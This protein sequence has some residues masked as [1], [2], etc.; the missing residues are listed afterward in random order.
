[1]TE[2]IYSLT[3]R[4]ERMNRIF[5]DSSK[6]RNCALLKSLN[7]DDNDRKKVFNSLMNVVYSCLIHHN[8]AKSYEL[9]PDFFD[10]Y[11][12][13]I[14]K[15]PNIT[16]NGLIL[17]KV[18]NIAA[19]NQFFLAINNA[20]SKIGIDEH[21]DKMQFPI[22]IRLQT[23]K[24]D[25]ELSRRP[26]ASTKYHSDIWAGDPLN[27]VL[28]FLNLVGDPVKIS[29]IEFFKTDNFPKKLVKLFEDYDEAKYIAKESE[30]LST[31]F[32]NSG[33]FFSDAYLMHRTT[34]N[35]GEGIRISADFRFTTREHCESDGE[36]SFLDKNKEDFFIEY[37]KF[38]EIGK[39]IFLHTEERM[40]DKFVKKDYMSGYPVK[41]TFK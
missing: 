17:P 25:K 8:E 28:S 18:E 34:K 1:M 9:C 10:I 22:N 12:D 21:I 30:K 16:P 14:L 38:K 2:E 39:S 3:S 27:S 36:N 23:G 26:R 19:Y 5:S 29:G 32:D 31:L 35:N 11:M 37:A 41:L 24:L 40:H 33:W 6:V 13:D 7:I 20:F 15:L 4:G